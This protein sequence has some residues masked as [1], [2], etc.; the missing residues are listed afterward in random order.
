MHEYGKG[1]T[2]EQ[3]LRIII[4]IERSIS[5][6]LGRFWLSAEISRQDVESLSSRYLVSETRND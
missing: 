3:T 2:K 6:F 1:L 4:F 5:H